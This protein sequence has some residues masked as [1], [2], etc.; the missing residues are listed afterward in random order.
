MGY[1]PDYIVCRHFFNII[2]GLA[3]K[4]HTKKV[5]S[6]VIELAGRQ[7]L[8]LVLFFGFQCIFKGIL[9]GWVCK[10]ICCLSGSASK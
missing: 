1:H 2:G 9:N 8:A 4:R 7:I 6:K 10:Y 5:S 3:S